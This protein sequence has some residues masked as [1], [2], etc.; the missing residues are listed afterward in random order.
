[1]GPGHGGS[2]GRKKGKK[3]EMMGSDALVLVPLVVL[4]SLVK[5]MGWWGHR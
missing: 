4:D 5:L 2:S 3:M 1:M